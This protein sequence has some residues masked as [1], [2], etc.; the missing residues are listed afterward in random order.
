M[1]VPINPCVEAPNFEEKLILDT[2]ILK[3]LEISRAAS[4]LAAA[5]GARG[6]AAQNPANAARRPGTARARRLL[7]ACAGTLHASSSSEASLP[8]LIVGYE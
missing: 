7:L 6:P 8:A 5:R 4:H 1:K 3:S 2:I